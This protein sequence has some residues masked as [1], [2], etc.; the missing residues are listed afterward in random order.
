MKGNSAKLVLV[1]SR[2][3]ESSVTENIQAGQGEREEMVGGTGEASSVYLCSRSYQ[4][5][6]GCG[7]RT[8]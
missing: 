7:R 5:F 1:A 4:P 6:K 8:I 2:S 3:S